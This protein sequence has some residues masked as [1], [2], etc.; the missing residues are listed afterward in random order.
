MVHIIGETVTEAERKHKLALKK[1]ELDAY[2]LFRRMFRILQENGY[3]GK[4]KVLTKELFDKFLNDGKTEE[5]G[6]AK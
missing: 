6:D 4:K 3:I 2:L 5:G 1:A